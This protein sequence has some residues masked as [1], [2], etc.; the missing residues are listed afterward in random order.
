MISCLPE[1]RGLDE[2]SAVAVYWR[3]LPHWRQPGATYF[4]TFRLADSIPKQVIESW[5][6]SR[7]VWLEAHNIKADWLTHEPERFSTAYQAISQ[8]EREQFEKHQ[9]RQ[10]TLSWID[11]MAAAC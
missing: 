4:V 5:R 7:R 10:C 6:K 1:F 11:A 8:T 2:G 9:I 3:N